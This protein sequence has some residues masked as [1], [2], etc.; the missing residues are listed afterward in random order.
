MRLTG[1]LLAALLALPAY[2]GS[3]SNAGAKGSRIVSADGAVTEILFA[4]GVEDRLVGV[5][6]TSKYPEDVNQLPKVGYLRALP[7][8]GVLS[9]EP[10][11]L[12]TTE[13]AEPEQT[14]QRLEQVGVKVTRLP[15]AQ[16]PEQTL[17]RIMAI[18]E[19]VDR[20]EA[21]ARLAGELQAVFTDIDKKV[22][23]RGSAPKVLVLLAAGGHGVSFGGSHTG[24]DALLKAIGATNAVSNIRGYKPASREAIISAS[25]DAIVV[26][27]SAP[28]QFRIADW[29]ELAQL[30]AW[31]NGHRYVGDSMMLLSFGPRL[32]EA[33]VILDGILPEAFNAE[34]TLASRHGD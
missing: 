2:A 4:L 32:A 33:L 28:G 31:K 19:L 14:L 29:P 22:A 11:H 10:D 3:A 1:L 5:D 15:V 25:P 12:I 16:S 30:P 18:G 26:A 21:A 20:E 24:A 7:F 6:T 23:A 27:E 34:S 9:L 8:E 17:Q 13:E